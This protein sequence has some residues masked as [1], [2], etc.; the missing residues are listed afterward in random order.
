MK[1]L[2][3]ISTLLLASCTSPVPIKQKFPDVPPVLLESCPKLEKAKDDEKDITKL[4]KVVIKNYGYYHQCS[5][6]HEQ[7]IEWYNKQKEIFDKANK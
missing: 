1:L 3:I 4:L 7:W 5:A 2:L 6:K